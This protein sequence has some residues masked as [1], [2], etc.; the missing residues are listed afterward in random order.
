MI[1]TLLFCS[2]FVCHV[3]M[4]DTLMLK[5]WSTHSLEQVSQRYQHQPYL[6]V[7]WSL[8][9]PTCYKEFE[10]LSAWK[11]KHPNANLIIVSTDSL[12][13]ASDVNAVLTEYQLEQSDT[14][15]FSDQP[16][17][18]VRNSIDPKWF[19]ELPRSYFF[20]A[21]HQAHSH[22]GALTTLQLKKWQ[23]FIA[24]N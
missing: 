24:R 8:E 16:T 12:N 7:F 18:M 19:G 9:C 5:Q 1:R 22:S 4:A 10:A 3:A 14:W 20:D 11:Q 23:Q 21:E 2:L 15:I 13:L 6:L 17:A